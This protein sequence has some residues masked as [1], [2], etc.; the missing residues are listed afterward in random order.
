MK[1]GELKASL[2]RFGLDFDDCEVLFVV[3]DDDLKERYDLLSFT[4]YVNVKGIDDPLF[5]LGSQEVALKMKSE[6]KI[7]LSED[8]SKPEDGFNINP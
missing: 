2:N 4:G 7:K 1:L 5:V 8:K 6:G 3:L